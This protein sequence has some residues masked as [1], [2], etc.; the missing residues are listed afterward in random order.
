[1]GPKIYPYLIHLINTITDTEIYPS[2]FK[3]QRILPILKPDKPCTIID[4]Y[5]PINNLSAMEKIIEQ[6]FKECMLDN[7]EINNVI[8]KNHHGS[9]KNHSTLTALASINHNLTTQYYDNKYTAI[10]QTDLSVAFDTIDHS[11]LIDKMEY[12]G[13]C[14]KALNIMHSFFSDRKQY[15]SIDNMESEL[16]GRKMS[17]LLYILYTNK[18]PLLGNIITNNDIFSKVTSSSNNIISNVYNYTIQ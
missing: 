18:I 13:I 3:V 9:L 5:R 1:M 6:Y 8:I 17:S 11:I 10:I 15:V 16:K 2:I 14:G 7:L 12:Y 4:S